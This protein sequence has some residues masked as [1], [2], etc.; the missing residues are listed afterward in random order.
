MHGRLATYED[1]LRGRA[2]FWP[3]RSIPIPRIG[4][5][6]STGLGLLDRY[7]GTTAVEFIQ[8]VPRCAA[9]ELCRRAASRGLARFSHPAYA[10][11]AGF[12]GSER[13]ALCDDLRRAARGRRHDSRG[14]PGHRTLPESAAER[15]RD[16][17][18]ASLTRAVTFQRAAESQNGL[19]LFVPVYREDPHRR[20]STEARLSGGPR[21]HSQR[22]RSSDPPWR[23]LEDMV[24]L[25]GLRRRRAARPPDVRIGRP[26]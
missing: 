20:R 16:T 15:A 2:G 24:A 3:P 1:A 26:G 18:M 12:P 9:R 5:A 17:G 19:M 21:W 6:T 10:W 23:K 22:M 14:R 25:A 8:W 11:C 4:T 7:P 13:R